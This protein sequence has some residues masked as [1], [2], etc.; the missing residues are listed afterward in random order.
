M[1]VYPQHL[2]NV[3]VKDKKGALAAKNVQQALKDVEEALGKQGRVL[4]RESGTEPVIRV[5]VE[6]E[7]DGL[8]KA[9]AK[10]LV[11]AIQ[12]SGYAL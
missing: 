7:N 2:T 5:M 1:K 6:G 10:R 9:L 3:R 12:D 4:L 8:C 11:C